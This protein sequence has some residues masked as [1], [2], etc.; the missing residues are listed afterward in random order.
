MGAKNQTNMH[1]VLPVYLMF[2][3]LLYQIIFVLRDYVLL[4][5]SNLNVSSLVFLNCTVWFEDVD[6]TLIFIG[7]Q[8]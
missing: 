4:Y 3:Y 1:F 5:D 7:S 8:T 6:L 2:I